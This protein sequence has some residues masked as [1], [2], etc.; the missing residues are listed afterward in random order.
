MSPHLIDTLYLVSTSLV[1]A[2]LWMLLKPDRA[3]RGHVLMGIGM[4]LA[5]LVTIAADEVR[6]SAGTA[7]IGLAVGAG[8]GALLGLRV[9]QEAVPGRLALLVAGVGLATALIVAIR[10]HE[11]GTAFDLIAQETQEKWKGVPDEFRR[12]NASS[13]A[14]RVPLRMSFP[15]VLATALGGIV[16]GAAGV[17]FLKLSKS[18]LRK[19]LPKLEYPGMPQLAAVVVCAVLGLLFAAWPTHETFLWLLLMSAMTLGYL[20]TIHLKIVDVLPVLAATVTVLGLSLGAAGMAIGNIVMV[21]LSG[22]VTSG[23]AVL[24]LSLSQS[25]NVSL[26]GLVRGTE[27]SRTASTGENE[28]ALR[29]PLPGPTTASADPN[30]PMI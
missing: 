3:N 26:L 16:A 21:T 1:L 30:A 24:A 28:S 10:L 22:L 7:F 20:L 8:L 14:L 6:A 5:V 29:S 23:G 13:Y 19:S 27:S 12:I 11:L 4:L 17:A 25:L 18:P 2:G 15:A 9:T